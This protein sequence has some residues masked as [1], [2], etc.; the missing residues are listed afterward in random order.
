MNVFMTVERIDESRDGQHAF[1]N[2]A[3]SARGYSLYVAEQLID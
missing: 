3:G 2:E 1:S